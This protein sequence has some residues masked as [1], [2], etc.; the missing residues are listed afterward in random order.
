VKVLEKLVAKLRLEVMSFKEL[1][2]AQMSERRASGATAGSR[3]MPPENLG[4]HEWNRREK[5]APSMI[6]R[7]LA[8]KVGETQEELQKVI[9]NL[10]PFATAAG[11][12]AGR[13]VSIRRVGH[14]EGR[15]VM[16]FAGQEWVVAPRV[17]I[18]EFQDVE[19]KMAVKRESWRLGR[20]FRSDISLDHALTLEQQKLRAAQWPMIQEAKAKGW[21]WCW[22]E[23]VP[24]RLIVNKGKIAVPDGAME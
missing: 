8:E 12:V 11:L 17:V 14:Q 16:P 15:N 1:Y 9:Y 6:I 22:S 3:S 18:V 2:E 13:V 23:V 21:R 19:S 4:S 10:A 24:H 20:G 7:R 5:L